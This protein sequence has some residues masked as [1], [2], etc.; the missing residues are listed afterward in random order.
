MKKLSVLLLC[1]CLLLACAVPAMA[2]ED[3]VFTV[4]ASAS[5]AGR[6]DTIEV[7]VEI[8]TGKAYTSL[9]IKPD[10]DPNVFEFVPQSGVAATVPDAIGDGFN[11][12]KQTLGFMFMQGK[13]Y[14][15]GLLRFKLKVKD[16]AAFAQATISLKEVTLAGA[17]HRIDKATVTIVCNHSYDT[18]TKV[19]EENHSAKCTICQQPAT[20][21]HT[22]DE[23]KVSEGAGC[24][25][26]G[27]KT[28]TC[29][30]CKAEKVEDVKVTG[31]SWDNAC[32]TKCNT[33][34]AEREIKHKYGEKHTS[35]EK[36]HWY[37]CSVCGHKKDYYEHTPDR[38]APTEKEAQLCKYCGY[39]IADKLAHVHEI[40]PQIQKDAEGH[41]Y[42]CSKLG[43][44]MRIDLQGHIY[45][46][47]CDMD[48]NVCE[49]IRI[50]PH[51]FKPE[52]RGSAEGH[53]RVCA[54][55][56]AES[57]IVPHV[58]GAPATEE[59]PQTCVD[60]QY[61]LQWPLNHVHTYG[62]E[63]EHDAQGHWQICQECQGKSE[64]QEHNWDEGT[65]ILEATEFHEGKIKHVCTDC[66]EEKTEII[67]VLDST[68]PTTPLQPTL[69]S[70]P[71][72]EE[73]FPW[74]IFGAAAG[75]LLIIGIVLLI[76][77]LIRSHKT[78]MH[79]KFS[80]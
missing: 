74:W 41:W 35:D 4:T 17:S 79:G 45:D 55:C 53:W 47:D 77:E 5:S 38:E 1:L 60:C 63:L 57:E 3:A 32:D 51:K 30:A 23:G 48:C 25:T 39:V 66:Q 14:S 9:G 76:I 31:H 18:Y 69:P 43:C 28:Y 72:E 37:E 16:S 44:Y 2:A 19:D 40:S 59:D 21:A 54:L 42:Y 24:E 62:E 12:Q 6:G 36:G 13:A 10:F 46:N 7:V 64:I 29:T 68:E 49:Y 56:N 80:K 75:V 67:P 15:G 8:E 26:P 22:W 11:E 52:W 70:E 27:K 33:C 65:V 34:G 20:S 71:G 78:N 58:P 73:G 50:P 61:W